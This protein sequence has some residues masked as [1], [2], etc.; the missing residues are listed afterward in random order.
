MIALRHLRYF[1]AVAEE[2]HVT[3]AALRLG[4][5]QP[6]LSQQIR[7]ME[8]E[9]GVALLNRLPRGVE[10]TEAGRVFLAEARLVITQ[11]EHAVE[12]ARRTARGEQGRLAVGFT[13]SAAF[14]PLIPAVV[15]AFRQAS[16]Q[17]DLLLE[18]SSTGELIAAL[19]KDQLDV[20]F[21]RVPLGD[22]AGIR[23]EPL[24]QE[25]MLVALPAH[26]PL[27]SKRAPKSI[28]L[29]RLADETFILYRRPTGPGLYDTIIAACRAAG[30]SP[31]IGQEAP[32]ML[33]TLS[34]VAAGL[35]ISII[36]ESMRR[37]DTEGIAYI[38]L[39]GADGMVA[40]LHLAWREE[41]PSGAAIRLIAQI[42]QMVREQ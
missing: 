15:R 38:P 39:A 12:A 29:A 36:P 25:K 10:L 7:A 24:L 3:R 18:E 30:F 40:P 42:R 41:H 23:I 27:A 26:H 31:R 17:V 28:A 13:S 11:V 14:H 6:P 5:Q 19:Q 9:I 22:T 35:G 21:L 8:A 16:P 4:I 37:L 20:A 2:G 34:L 33:S 1:I 32:R